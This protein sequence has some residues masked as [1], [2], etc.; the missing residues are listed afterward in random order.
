MPT[1]PRIMSCKGYFTMDDF[2]VDIGKQRCK[3][4]LNVSS[5]KWRGNYRWDKVLMEKTYVC[6]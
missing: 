6:L 1:I 4:D 2:T 3:Y 5:Y